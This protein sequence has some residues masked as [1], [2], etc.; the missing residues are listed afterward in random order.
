MRPLSAPSTIRLAMLAILAFTA[1]ASAAETLPYMPT[2]I[3][4]AGSNPAA[5]ATG[6]R[7]NG[8]AYILSPS[9]ES[10]DLLAL[11][12][13]TTLKAGS[14]NTKTLTVGLPFA[15]G[16]MTKA[17]AP[18]ISDNGTI[19]VFAG[20][21]A[22]PTASELWT[23]TPTN[24]TSETAQWIK[25]TTKSG[26]S[27]DGQAA[28]YFLGGSLSFSAQVAPVVSAPV[29]YV[30]GGMC[31]WA[32]TT[33]S[34]PQA[35]AMYSRRMF[36]VTP[37]S[38][39]PSD[40]FSVGVA[41]GG[42]QPPV[43][44]AGFT[45]TALTP[46]ISNRS[47]TVTQQ[48]SYVVLGGHTQ[49]AFVNM[50]TA[51]IWSL[52]E[53]TWN[54]VNIHSPVAKG[55]TELAIRDLDIT[56]R[57]G[58]TTVLS[59]DGNRLV[60]FGGWVGDTAQ[61][62]SP[63]L[64]I[65]EI[66]S[67][68][69]EWQWSV[70]TAQSQGSGI[71][72]HGAV[73]LP[74]N[75]MMV[76][77]GYS[78]SS[79]TTKQ[80]REDGAVGTTT[81]FFNLT[82]ETW[83]NEYSNPSPSSSPGNTGNAGP[84][85][86]AADDSSRNRKIGLGV[87]LGLGIPLALATIVVAVL[88]FR[89]HQK[90][91]RYQ[92]ESD[93]RGLAQD[94]SHFLHDPTDGPGAEDEMME[95]DGFGN[96]RFFP[97]NASTARSWYTGGH[98]PYLTGGRSL[99]YESLRGG[100]RG[101]PIP[102]APIV[103]IGRPRNARG[104]YQPTTSVTSSYDFASTRATGKIHPIYEADEDEQPRNNDDHGDLGVSGPLISPDADED[105][106][107]TPAA[108][109]PTGAPSGGL[110]PN[111]DSG[112]RGS[113]TPSPE[114]HSG[115]RGQDR[116]VRDWVL[117]VDAADAVLAAR[118]SPH[119]A[120]TTRTT[121]DTP[122]TT[123]TTTTTTTLLTTTAATT[124]TSPPLSAVPAPLNINRQGRTSP[125]RRSSVR[126]SGPA[127]L[128]QGELDDG[129]TASNLSEG[130]YSFVQGGTATATSRSDSVRSHFRNA[131]GGP[132]ATTVA[133]PGISAAATE[134]RLDSSS[135]SEQTYSTARSKPDFTTLQAQGPSLLHHG[136]TQ[137]IRPED[138]D[139]EDFV[140]IPG[141]P[142][143]SRP[144]RSWLGSLKR[145]FSGSTPSPTGSSRE[146]S[147]THD[148]GGSSNFESRLVGMGPGG[149]LLRRKQ[150]REAWE[151]A[152]ATRDGMGAAENEDEW[153]IERAVEQRL[154]QVMFTVP[155]ERLR[156]VNAEV[157]REEEVVVV[158]LEEETF[159]EPE[160]EYVGEENDAFDPEKAAMRA[161]E[162]DDGDIGKGRELKEYFDTE[163]DE[164]PSERTDSMN[165]TTFHTA[166]AVRLERRRTR[167]LEMVESI[168]SL[169]RE[170]SPASSPQRGR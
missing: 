149:M 90:N 93:L 1:L 5:W 124:I 49:Q 86:S 71:Y 117:D 81:M 20:E 30:Y 145:V 79:S 95:H 11:D 12:I 35:G 104:L 141:S 32:N 109:T 89:R 58:H 47:G 102:P 16:A 63:Q 92:R 37:P 19:T 21:C 2:T 160:D 135:S 116:E 52:P 105:P 108:G 140:P 131:F 48:A 77:G 166:E 50:S 169:S 139:E 26:S 83:S 168:E 121:I 23:Y 125:T 88:W 51:A 164:A 156:V 36:K 17:F 151:A 98:D 53:E 137:G 143:K 101:Y 146:N 45:F 107:M 106:F 61:A 100:S 67:S 123:T 10:A 60:I 40:P 120:T 6:I 134:A 31:P 34:T 87:G 154:V 28:P 44:E 113:S 152:A 165:T 72:G 69:G 119:N 84:S 112:S 7:S 24:S 94:A 38:T 159:D 39:N 27:L 97:W 43:A 130:A 161:A 103:S 85:S 46:A 127:A 157:E 80:K 41:S 82:S 155:K 115:S 65:I 56:S 42:S 150:G 78:V 144:R 14:I 114:R 111:V 55:Q 158:D 99:G 133:A 128:A 147:P 162:E 118:I 25:H 138:D 96:G 122:E 33:G 126:A 64:A 129:R 136:E 91:R 18:S 22:S 59:E 110:F 13:S 148:E 76:Y 163:A 66:G 74:G 167:V 62:A 9:G 73:L 8:L 142:S 3:L 132:T 68:L 4:I 75:V 153:D 54:F 57:S 15:D 70:P 170:H 29:T